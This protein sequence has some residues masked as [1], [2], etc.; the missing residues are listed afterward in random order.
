[1]LKRI[2][3]V[4]AAALVSCTALVADFSYTN[5]AQLTGGL[6]KAAAFLSKQLREPIK[7]TVMVKGDRMVTLGPQTAHIVDL[8]A[9]TVTEV[10]FKKKTYSVTTFAQLA[11]MMRQLDT[12][13]KDQKGH[14]VKDMTV[15]ATVKKTGQTR[16]IGGFD[17]H[18]VILTV[19]MQGTDEKTG[20]KAVAMEM[21]SDMWLASQIPG[22]QEVR[23]FYRRMAQKVNWVPSM[24]MMSQQGSSKGMAE[25]V[26]EM[27]KL[28]GVPVLQLM[29][30]GGAGQQVSAEET[31]NSQQQAEKE[32]PSS[33]GTLGRLAGGSL[34]RFGGFGRKKQQEQEQEQEQ[35][36]KA[37]NSQGGSAGAPTLMEMRTELSDFSTGPV[38]PSKFEVPAGFKQVESEMLKT[39]RR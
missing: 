13:M 20:E 11:E 21:V 9:E 7:T 8:N 37:S 4:T 28:D 10:D 34:G 16:T 39:R 12:S 1:M 2:A 5:T 14:G 32:K 15:T 36:S 22:Y 33:G 19:D 31:Q 38:D 24:G 17:T 25:M 6:M 18:E 35:P 29:K 3:L 26:K 27:S 23:D 30:M